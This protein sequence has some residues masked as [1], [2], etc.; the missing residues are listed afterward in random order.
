[1]NHLIKD[2]ISLTENKLIKY[3]CMLKKKSIGNA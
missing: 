1:M 2:P 3:M